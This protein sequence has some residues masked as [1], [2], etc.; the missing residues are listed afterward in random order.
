MSAHGDGMHAHRPSVVAAV[1]TSALGVLVTWRADKTP[2]AGFLSGEIEPGESPGEAV[3][4]ECR[5]EA[6]LAVRAGQVIAERLHPRTGRHMIYVA[7]EPVDGTDVR[8]EHGSG[9]TQVRWVS[10]DQAEAA[11]AEF[12]GIYPPVRDY[13]IVQVQTHPDV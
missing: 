12:C 8:A 7:G 11:M 13:L 3:I 9:L 6:G 4:R 5:E 1:I 10:L 2:P